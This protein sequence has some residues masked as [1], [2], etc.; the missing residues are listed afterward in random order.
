[1]DFIFYECFDGPAIDVY[2]L[3]SKYEGYI[4]VQV[5]DLPN[6]LQNAC[7]LYGVKL[8]E[9]LP[10]SAYKVE[11]VH[12][13]YCIVAFRFIKQFEW[14]VNDYKFVK[15]FFEDFLPNA[16]PLNTITPLEPV[17]LNLSLYG[18]DLEKYERKKSWVVLKN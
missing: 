13:R 18:K 6:K 8:D 1:M 16:I 3:S 14:L 7:L 5:Q 17:S 12:N 11:K 9:K 10:V 2:N 15:Q 4:L